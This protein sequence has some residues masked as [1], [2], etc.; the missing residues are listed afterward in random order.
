MRIPS[1][2]L[3]AFFVV[4]F[5][6]GVP[7]SAEEAEKVVFN[8]SVDVAYIEP[9]KEK[10]WNDQENP[11]TVCSLVW[12]SILEKGEY[13]LFLDF[14]R[15]RQ[16]AER[17]VISSPEFPEFE[18]IERTVSVAGRES[19]GA[20]K[21]EKRGYYRFEYD[22][23][24]TRDEV[25]S[26]IFEAKKDSG[27]KV[28]VPK[29]A[30]SPSV[31]L[32]WSPEDGKKRNYD[33]LYGEINVPEGFD[34]MYT[35]WMSLGFCRGYFGIQVNSATERRVL[36]SIWDSSNEAV[37][38]AKVKPE[39]RVMLIDKGEDVYGGGFGNEGTGGQTYWKYPWKTG[40]TVRFIMNVRHL[41]DD[42][43]L[44]S[45]WFMDEEKEGWKYVSTWQAPREKRYLDGFYSFLENFGHRNGQAIRKGY[46]MNSWGHEADG[47]WVELNRVNVTN[48]D[49]K[50]DGRYDYEGG[51]ALDDSNRFYMQ[52]GGY[53][54]PKHQKGAVTVEKTN[55]PPKAD[56]DV[57]NKRIDEAVENSKKRNEK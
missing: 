57:L 44:Y 8:L 51:K 10:P 55:M 43:V 19:L 18:K 34:P 37:D 38:R 24:A 54:A 42:F 6:S 3:A 23:P 27:A 4:V 47:D 50:T 2:A 12:Y 53:T 32:W 11:K 7:S 21:I 16:K 13:E 29:H 35:Y 52:S 28:I 46:Y 36:F 40:K 41:P 31:H 17:F 39:D 25:K 14:A 30:S 49:G 56:L 9:W 33:W 15:D 26:L 5:F 22:S 45:A 1:F 48:T 20:L